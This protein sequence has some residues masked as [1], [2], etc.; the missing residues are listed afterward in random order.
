MQVVTEL[1]TE[2]DPTCSE[3][4]VEGVSPP[5]VG[6]QTPM[7]ADK[8]AI[9]RHPLFPLLALLFEKC[10]QST[11]GSEGTTSASFD[12]DIEN[13]VR[14]Q[15]KEGKPFFCEDPETDNLMVKAIQVLR[16]HLLELE[17]VNELCKD[18]CSRYIACLKTKMNSETLLSGEP[19]SPY[20]PVQSQ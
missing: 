3:P 12:V 5:P 15:E 8:Q 2:Q 16:I 17:K 9:Y 10:E 1:K 11:Q 4:D 20:S 18:F 13:F 14:K 6:S 19:G 7:D